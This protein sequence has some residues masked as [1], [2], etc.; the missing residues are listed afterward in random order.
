MIGRTLK[1]F[2]KVSQQFF[3]RFTM[4]RMKPT[5]FNK[6]EKSIRGHHI[7]NTTPI[8]E[9]VWENVFKCALKHDGLSPQCKNGSHLPGKDV[10]AVFDDDT[11]QKYSCKSCKIHRGII[12]ISSYR[13]TTCTTIP[14]FIY[15]IDVKRN[16]FDSYAI[17]AREDV[18]EEQEILY[19]LYMIPSSF[20]KAGDFQWKEHYSTSERFT[21]WHTDT[22]DGMSMSITKSMSNQLWIKIP[23]ENIRSFKV[24]ETVHWNKNLQQQYDYIEL[25]DKLSVSCDSVSCAFSR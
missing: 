11:T 17:L 20:I 24:C 23:I 21:G 1:K 3:T 4:D 16:N 15:E 5:F 10:T 18:I 22:K 6:L 9:S 12:S 7:S 19:T 14:Q 13:L 2:D 8:K 25:V